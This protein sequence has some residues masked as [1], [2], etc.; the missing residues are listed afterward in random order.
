M[1]LFDN[2]LIINNDNDDLITDYKN[3][4]Y[5]PKFIE[6][7]KKWFDFIITYNDNSHNI[8]DYIKDVNT[9]NITLVAQSN[10]DNDIIIPITYLSEYK[11]PVEIECVILKGVM[12]VK[13]ITL[14]MYSPIILNIDEE[15]TSEYY[16]TTITQ[17]DIDILKTKN[18]NNIDKININGDFDS[19]DT[20]INFL[21]FFNQLNINVYINFNTKI[22][23]DNILYNIDEIIKFNIFNLDII[24]IN[25]RNYISYKKIIYSKI[26]R[27]FNQ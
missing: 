1:G 3:N 2:E 22:T 5:K 19:L 25:E 15:G 7:F 12:P 6:F 17:K 21:D 11:L 14:F 13:K 26:I 27:E 20:F 24:H 9:D 23:I 8:I 10:N 16:Y 18:F 4:V